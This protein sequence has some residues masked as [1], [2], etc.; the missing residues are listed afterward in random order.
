M[1]GENLHVGWR[2]VVLGVALIFAALGALAWSV[3]QNPEFAINRVE[4]VDIPEPTA[5]ARGLHA[6]S[7]VADLHAD[8]LLFGRDLLERSDVGHV[9][10]P[11]LREGGVGLQFF[12]AATVMPMSTDP[13]D[14]S[15]DA[16]DLIQ[17]LG[18]VMGT[19][20]ASQ[21]ALARALWQ[22][23]RLDGFAQRSNGRLVI[24]ENRRDLERW[25][26]M[27]EQDAGVI[28]A[29]LGIEGA[30]AL[31][32]NISNLDVAFDAGFRVLGLAHFFDNAFAGSAHGRRKGGLSEMGRELVRRM[33]SKGVAV[34][35]AHVSPFAIRDVLR[36][37]TRPTLVS[38]TGVRATCDNPRNLSDDQ[39]RGIARGGGVIG[40]GYFDLAVCGREPRHIVS[41]IRHV[42]DLVGD[43]HVALGSDFDGGVV[44]ALDATGHIHVTQRMLDEGLSPS[45]IRKVLGENTL[46]VMAQLLPSSRE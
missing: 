42:I 19:P 14:T 23:G 43:D 15:A 8:S 45:T 46:R 11:R 38:H 34:D 18:R 6:A 4:W 41:A 2:R 20:L 29:V 12:T 27:H 36:I 17:L 7:L 3:A 21:S 31:E 32:A 9:D 40:I 44:T 35:L 37:A 26:R 1:A 10:L 5:L 28:G 16:P 25:R 22:A 30:H 13:H 24:I 33:E 39:I